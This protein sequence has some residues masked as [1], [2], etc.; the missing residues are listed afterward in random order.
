MVRIERKKV[1][2]YMLAYYNQERLIIIG[3]FDKVIYSY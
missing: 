3:Y 1:V 2:C